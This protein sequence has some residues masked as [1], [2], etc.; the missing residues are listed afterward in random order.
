MNGIEFKSQDELRILSAALC[1][2]E[3]DADDGSGMY[4][5]GDSATICRMKHRVDA[6][7]TARYEAKQ[8]VS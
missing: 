8:A 5:N 6:E 2:A 3:D 4:D 1:T 7:L